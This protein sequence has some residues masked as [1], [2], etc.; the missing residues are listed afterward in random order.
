MK[1]RYLPVFAVALSLAASLGAQDAGSAAPAAQSN[2]SGQGGG[3]GQRGGRGGGFGG[4]MMGRGL[5]GTVTE[6]AADHYLMKTETGD[7]YTVTLGSSTRIVKQA[8]G[9][10]GQGGGVAGGQGG[11]QGMG[12]GMGRGNP[13]QEIKAGD[14]K[15]G[16]MI[17]VMG[18]TDATAKKVDART[19]AL[20]DPQRAQQMKEMEAN[21]GKTWVMGKVTAIDGTKITLTGT[22]DNAAHTAIADENTTFRKGRDPVTLADI[23]VGDT[24]RVDGALKDGVFAATTVSV[25][26]MG[27]ATPSVPRNAPPQ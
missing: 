7:V 19:V 1:F 24:V 18:D 11:G 2:G 6:A 17:T 8:A 27:G 26:G 21:F 15:V 3:N 16:D 12:G 20:V 9:M 23:Q 14:I 22:V 10:R 4:G 13:P 5:M 25:G